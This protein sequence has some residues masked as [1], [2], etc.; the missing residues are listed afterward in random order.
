MLRRST[1]LSE[2]IKRVGVSSERECGSGEVKCRWDAAP[3]FE[4]VVSAEG[5][6]GDNVGIGGLF[7]A[8]DWRRLVRESC[9]GVSVVAMLK[10]GSDARY[11]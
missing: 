1:G 5:R 10:S 11:S 2:E 9:E 6:S 3:R 7:E 8:I 4:V